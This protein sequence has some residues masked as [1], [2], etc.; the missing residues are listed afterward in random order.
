MAPVAFFS[1][2]LREAGV[3]RGSSLRFEDFAVACLAMDPAICDSPREGEVLIDG[4]ECSKRVRHA[5]LEKE[6]CVCSHW[7]SPG[8]VKYPALAVNF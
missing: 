1:K 7:L 2:F 4:A 5:W 6:S 8:F 3:E